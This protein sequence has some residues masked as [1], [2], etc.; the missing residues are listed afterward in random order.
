MPR[1]YYKYNRQKH[2]EPNKRIELLVLK[3][4]AGVSYQQAA[5]ALGLH[6]ST[7][8]SM[9]NGSTAM[10]KRHAAA[11]EEYL[12]NAPP[13]VREKRSMADATALKIRRLQA[14][15]TGREIAENIGCTSSHVHSMLR[16]EVGMSTK[17]AT[18]I[19]QYLDGRAADE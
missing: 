3:N 19:E 4:R 11:L 9:M 7:V 18:K 14:H 5:D 17:W 2:A 6:K 13:G 15:V 8:T 1:R 16:G 10:A 12:S